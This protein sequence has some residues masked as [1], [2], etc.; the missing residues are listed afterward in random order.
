MENNVPVYYPE[1]RTIKPS[2]VVPLPFAPA[3]GERFSAYPLVEALL[4]GRNP[5][6]LEAYRQDLGDLLCLRGAAT[7]DGAA[8]LLQTVERVRERFGGLVLRTAIRENVRPKEAPSFMQPITI[9]APRS[10]GAEDYRAAAAELLRR[11]RK[12]R[13]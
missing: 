2:T 10:P 8:S 4:A 11:A 12:R 6:A 5:R 13:S 9:Y 3:A 1:V 7:L